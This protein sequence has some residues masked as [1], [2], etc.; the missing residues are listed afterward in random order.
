MADELAR[1]AVALE[2]IADA[3]EHCARRPVKVR[4]ARRRRQAMPVEKP[5]L[6]VSDIDRA[7]AREELRRHGLI[8]RS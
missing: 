1:I 2:R 5:P 6:P 7:F 3:M 4:P 8:R